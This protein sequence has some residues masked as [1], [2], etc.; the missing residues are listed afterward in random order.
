[1][2]IVD[3]CS[4]D[5]T[6]AVLEERISRMV[7]RIIYHPIKAAELGTAADKY[8]VEQCMK[9]RFFSSVWNGIGN[10]VAE[11]SLKNA[12]M[13]ILKQK[14]SGWKGRLNRLELKHARDRDISKKLLRLYGQSHIHWSIAE[15]SSLHASNTA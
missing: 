11:A 12:S 9:Q 8:V 4:Q 6:Q 1:M 10:H 14:T 5:G 15:S 3:D 2:I 7:D 13:I